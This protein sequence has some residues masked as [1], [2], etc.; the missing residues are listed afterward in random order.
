[1]S[2]ERGIRKVQKRNLSHGVPATRGD[3]SFEICWGGGG[4]G[5]GGGVTVY[6][7]GGGRKY[8]QNDVW[9]LI[10]DTNKQPTSTRE[11]ESLAGERTAKSED[12]ST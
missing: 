11:K 6:D 5:G 12:K 1:M 7:G 2:A 3:R 8:G 4:G 9:S 10:K